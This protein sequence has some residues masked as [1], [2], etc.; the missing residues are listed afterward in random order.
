MS[1]INLFK[2]DKNKA[3]EL[4]SET[5]VI[6]RELQNIIE[7]N[8]NEFFG[9]TF[10]DS[11]YSI[12]GGRI[13]SLGLDENYS[14]VIFEYKRSSSENVIN[15]GLFYMDW[16]VTHQDSFYLLVMNKLGKEIADKI[17]WSL[18]RLYCV[19]SNFTKYDENAIKQMSRNIS[20]FRY[21]KYN[22]DLILLE[23][24]SSNI[25]I[26]KPVLINETKTNTKSNDLSFLEKYD[27]A[28]K[29][30]RELY[31]DIRLFILS[32]G[33]DVTENQ[34]KLYVAFKKTKNIICSEIHSAEI[35]C[36]LRL[37]PK[38]YV[39]E[40]GFTKDMSSIGHWGTGDLEV[41]IKNSN[42]F[43]KAKHLFEDAYNKN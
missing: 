9:T 30:I 37:D 27:R 25:N 38:S 5:V 1:E 42:D 11:E 21:K 12:D 20:L 2:L 24:L 16:L 26:K 33:D 15:Q 19:A 41:R 39:L 28:N 36:Y 14:P 7:Q 13:D 35:L 8:M 18:P 4:P 32:L 6:E 3:V 29:K 31:E 23:L 10:L 17:D 43:E 34:L 40:D 22:S